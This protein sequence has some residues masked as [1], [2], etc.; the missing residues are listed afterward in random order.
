[1]NCEAVIAGKHYIDITTRDNVSIEK[2]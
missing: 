2:M 1:M